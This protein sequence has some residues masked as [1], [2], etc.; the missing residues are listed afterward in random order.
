M[1]VDTT[2]TASTAAGLATVDTAIQSQKYLPIL[3]ATSTPVH[4]YLLA[5]ATENKTRNVRINETPRRVR[6]TVE[7]Q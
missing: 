3:T 6:E 2:A 7:K 4:N 1:T 5:D